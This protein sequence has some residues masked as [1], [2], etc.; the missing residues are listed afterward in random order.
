MSGRHGEIDSTR[1]YNLL[2]EVDQ[3]HEA[4]QLYEDQC[5]YFTQLSKNCNKV[6]KLQ[7]IAAITFL[8]YFNSYISLESYWKSW[9]LAGA[10]QAAELLDVPL[11]Q[12]AHT[13]NPLESFNGCIKGKYFAPYM[14]S[15]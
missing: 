13:T 9:S 2:K 3:Y 7:G 11:D 6:P 4:K 12:I 1:I 8:D 5:Q 15:G 14:H 10:K